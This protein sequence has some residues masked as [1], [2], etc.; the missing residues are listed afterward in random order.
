MVAEEVA[1]VRDR[2]A[3][4]TGVTYGNMCA[5]LSDYIGQVFECKADRSHYWRTA[6]R[7]REEHDSR[8]GRF[9]EKFEIRNSRFLERRTRSFEHRITLFPP[10]SPV[11]LKHGLCAPFL[12]F[13][14]PIT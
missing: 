12:D 7:A 13:A 5:K 10:V 6:V 14:Y 2:R 4:R 3:E 9:G 11:L 8:D 1:D